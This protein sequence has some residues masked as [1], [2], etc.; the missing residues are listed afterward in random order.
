MAEG[1]EPLSVF[2]GIRSHGID[3]RARNLS[4]ETV[5]EALLLRVRYPSSAL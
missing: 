5:S 2:E 3:L 4:E 1:G